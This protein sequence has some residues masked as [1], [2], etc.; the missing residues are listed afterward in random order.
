MYRYANLNIQPLWY[1]AINYYLKW[2]KCDDQM[3]L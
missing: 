3:V 1:G 2:I